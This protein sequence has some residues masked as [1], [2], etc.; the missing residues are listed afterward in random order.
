[1]NKKWIKSIVWLVIALLIAG[2][3]YGAVRA[4]NAPLAP[5]LTLPTAT[6]AA[7]DAEKVCNESGT[8]TIL[9][10][11]DDVNHGVWPNGAD[12]IRLVKVDYSN[13]KVIVITFP[14]DLF[15]KAVGLESQ[16]I[17]EQRL[18]LIYFYGKQN[19]GS[20]TVADQLS[21]GSDVLA[22]TIT[23]DF[24]VQPNNYLVMDMSLI[25]SLVDSVGGIEVDLPAPVVGNDNTTFPAGIQT[26]TGAQV[27][28]FVSFLKTDD[29]APRFERQEIVIKAFLKKALSTDAITKIP[30]MIKQAGANLKTDLS[31]DQ[32]IN[33]GCMAQK[34]SAD[35]IAFYN[36]EGSDF[37]TKNSDGEIVPNTDVVVKFLQE[38]LK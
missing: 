7:S 35:Q 28:T 36:I 14:R 22:K 24:G 12:L 6:A 8:R 2:G 32:I 18:G 21:A 20:T 9:W 15:V 10:I 17:V 30:D 13:Q 37:Y 4:F 38:K 1:M 26:L 5:A 31:V 27:V 11:G 34:V 3:S 25:A 16:N 23:S 19:A 33:L 29:E